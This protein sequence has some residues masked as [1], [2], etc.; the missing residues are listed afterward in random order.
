MIRSA[1]PLLLL[2]AFFLGS[3][4][5]DPIPG[6]HISEPRLIAHRGGVVGDAH[7]ENS[8]GSVEAAIAA[9]YWMIEVD[10]RES[11]D[12]MMVVHHDEDFERFYGDGRLLAEMTWDEIAELRATPG[13]TR[14]LLFAE[15]AELCRGRMR[16]MLDTKP[17]E[18]SEQFFEEMERVL[19]EN[20]LLESAFVIGT[21]QSR[22]WFD[23]KAKVG[24]DRGGLRSA[25]ER[26]E[27]IAALY[28]LFEHGRDLDAETVG[29][30]RELGV[31]VVPSINVFHYDDLADHMAAA[32]SDVLGML[33]AGVVYFQIDSVY[34]RWLR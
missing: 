19:V 23:G 6:G 11:A 31:D 24:V 10:V 17:P 22:A 13:D 30:A 25:I 29:W 3:C 33:D 2:A 32:E 1:A 18:H 12:G 4:V 15:L 28:Y 14:P 16:L 27:D 7:A 21:E 20:D 9:G 34:D 5:Y 8:P 26:G